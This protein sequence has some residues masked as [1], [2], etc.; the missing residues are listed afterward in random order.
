[1]SLWKEALTEYERAMKLSALAM[2]AHNPM[3]TKIKQAM[4]KMRMKVRNKVQ[5]PE[6]L[7]L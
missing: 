1:M 4:N 3:T 5:L 7:L 2:K 6:K